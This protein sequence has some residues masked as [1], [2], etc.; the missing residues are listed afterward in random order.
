MPKVGMWS[1][2]VGESARDVILGRTAFLERKDYFT[3]S[4]SNTAPH[5][6][7]SLIAGGY[8]SR[9][10]E[11]GPQR[12]G[13]DVKY[14]RCKVCVASAMPRMDATSR[15]MDVLSNRSSVSSLGA[16][17][18]LLRLQHTPSS[19]EG[20]ASIAQL[21]VRDCIVNVQSERRD[22]NLLPLQAVPEANLDEEKLPLMNLM[23]KWPFSWVDS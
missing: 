5:L 23:H 17:Q 7:E 9:V 18:S 6:P 21:S 2:P 14:G 4:D 15:T 3:G 13:Q 12:A 20:P 19:E 22:V 8:S 11:R 16:D 1:R 10:L